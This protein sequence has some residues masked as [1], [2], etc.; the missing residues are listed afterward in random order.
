MGLRSRL[1]RR[2]SHDF[3]TDNQAR[4]E[5]WLRTTLAAVP[6]GWRILDA[7]AGQQH[8]KPFCN[9][10]DYV[11]QDLAEYDGDGDTKGLQAGSWD[12]HHVDIVSDITSIPVPSASFDAAMCI[13][14]L[15]HVPDPKAALRELCRVVRPH[16][17]VIVTAPFASL[18]HQSPYYYHSGFAPR[19]FEK[20]LTEFGCVIE[21]IDINGDF[22]RYL[23]QELNRASSVAKRY[24][25]RRFGPLGQVSMAWAVHTLAKAA[26]RDRG[27]NEL[28]CW[29]LHVKARR[30][31]A[32]T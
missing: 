14:V 24:S 27:S 20:W 17:L 30:V 2:L 23:A 29:G 31:V 4:R 18:V 32:D 28:L 13:E 5:L 22:F 16:G 6:A 19:Y 7:G 21:E 9:H 8:Y 3:G 15:E 10:L 25:G 12:A 1:I 26:R 11:A